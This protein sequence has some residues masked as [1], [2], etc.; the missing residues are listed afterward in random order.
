MIRE[1]IQRVFQDTTETSAVHG[2][3]YTDEQILNVLRKADRPF[4]QT[5]RFAK[6]LGCSKRTAQKRLNTLEEEE[7]VVS[8]EIG[9][10]KVWWL[11]D[12]EPHQ[13]VKESGARILRLSTLLTAYTTGVFQTWILLF[14]ASGFLLLVYLTANAQGMELP[15]FG[16][17]GITIAA[18]LLALSG[19]IGV[20]I[21]G[22]LK[23]ANAILRTALRRE[24]IGT[25]G[26]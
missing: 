9:Q 10:A 24:W 23:G 7:R 1:R 19:G 13:P 16:N 22:F 3:S 4:T 6:E 2:K 11:D 5:K 8:K 21:W 25:I 26:T 14:G 15:I 17:E 18:F 12:A 20:G